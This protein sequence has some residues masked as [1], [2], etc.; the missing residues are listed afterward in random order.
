MSHEIELAKRKIKKTPPGEKRI[1]SEKY[2]YDVQVI[3]ETCSKWWVRVLILEDE[4]LVLTRR[5]LIVG[6]QKE[7]VESALEIGECYFRANEGRLT[8]AN[9]PVM[10]P[11]FAEA[12]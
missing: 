12:V 5:I 10:L 2:R 11:E 3:V 4:F 7:A 8:L 1:G 9:Q 6:T